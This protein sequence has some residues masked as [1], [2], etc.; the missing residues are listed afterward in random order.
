MCDTECCHDGRWNCL[1]ISQVVFYPHHFS[2]A[3]ISPYNIQ[4]S[5]Q[6]SWVQTQ[7]TQF[8][9]GWKIQSS[10]PWCWIL[11]DTLFSHEEN[12]V[13][14]TENSE[15]WFQD[16][17]H[18]PKFHLPWWHFQ[19]SWILKRHNRATPIKLT[20]AVAIVQPSKHME[21]ISH[22]LAPCSNLLLKCFQQNQKRHSD[23]QKFP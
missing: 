6:C 16:H 14:S 13:I 10:S 17:N 12:W 4:S 11:I 8:H 3:L 15:P 21:Q 18:R 5:P 23:P 9:Q 2:N 7:L 22:S 19:K 1:P 20:N